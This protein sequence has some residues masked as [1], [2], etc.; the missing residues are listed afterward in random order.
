MMKRLRSV[1]KLVCTALLL[2]AFLSCQGK[3][4]PQTTSSQPVVPGVEVLLNEQM[5]WVAGKRVGLITNPTG[6]TR[7]LQAT[8]D[9]LYAHPQIRLEAL[10]GPE[11]GVRG[12][13]AAGAP[14]ATFTDDKTGLPVF[15]LYGAAKKPTAEMLKEIDVLVFDIQD[16]GVRPYTYIYT[17]AYAMQ[18][19][20]EQN[21]PIIVLDRPNPMGGVHVEGPVLEEQFSSFIG[22]YPIAY[23]HGMTVGELARYFNQEFHIDAELHVVPMRGW[24]RDMIF[25]D[26]GLPWVPTSPH[27]PQ[28]FTPFY[29]A[30]VGALGE[31]SSVNIGIGY[32][33]PFQLVGSEWI[34]GEKLCGALNAL[35]LPGVR[36]RA[37]YYTPFY[38]NKAGI[39]LQGVQLHF[40]DRGVAPVRTQIALIHCLARLFSPESLF[41]GNLRMFRL[42]MGTDRIDLAIRRGED[43]E[44]VTALANIGLDEFLQKRQNYLLY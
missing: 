3:P 20:K 33:L 27:V 24:R 9:V 26:T 41:S 42:A 43:L 13:R 6:V 30:A 32:T 5:E 14:V 16:V 37:V 7:R 8:I 4:L 29:Q 22:L 11:H 21:I 12:N 19:A 25:S 2:S 34:D 1:S 10:F 40:T 18:A 36:F 44:A 23:V 39:D 35:D 31:L 15:S 28:S 38:G 17:M